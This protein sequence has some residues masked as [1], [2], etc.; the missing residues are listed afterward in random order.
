MG[1]TIERQREMMKSVA[2]WER[3]WIGEGYDCRFGDFF[4]ECDGC[5][6]LEMV[7]WLSVMQAVVATEATI[8]S[9]S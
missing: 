5:G 9:D 3:R 1:E 8:F 7:R 2:M 4:G 6:V